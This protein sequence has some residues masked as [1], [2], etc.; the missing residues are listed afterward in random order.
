MQPRFLHV[1][2]TMIAFDA[3]RY[4]VAVAIGVLIF[5]VWGRERFRS[6]RIA[7][8]SPAA[9]SIRRELAY[10][11]STAIIFSLNGVALFYGTRRGVFHLY[12]HWSDHGI[13]YFAFTVLMLPLLHDTYFYWTHRAMHHPKIF[14]IV[15]AVHHQS[16]N[17]SPAAAYAF[18][19][20][21][22]AIQASYVPLVASFF[23]VSD[24][25]LFLFL[26]FMIFRNVLG[27]LGI[28][29]FPRWFVKNRWTSWSTTATHHAMHHSRF[30]SNYGLYLTFWD[31]VMKTTH[32]GYEATF[33][34]IASGGKSARVQRQVDADHDADDRGDRP[35][36]DALTTASR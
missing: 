19:P 5:W 34:A 28:E 6:R 11:A 35:H 16:N 36:E 15:H 3:G 8:R 14:R 9:A 30:R 10:S 17:P 29:P 21:E 18:G 26:T 12:P 13:A 2:A 23:S 25:A 7:R 24:V 1:W 22:A 31:R 33:D 27:H 32:E 20:I 4:I